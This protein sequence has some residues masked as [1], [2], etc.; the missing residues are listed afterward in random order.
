MKY[1]VSSSLQSV[2][3]RNCKYFIIFMPNYIRNFA[4]GEDKK[5]GPKQGEEGVKPEIF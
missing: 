5:G 4:K 3:I 1:P 2:V